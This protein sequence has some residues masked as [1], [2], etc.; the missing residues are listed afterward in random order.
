MG[1]ASFEKQ[2]KNSLDETLVN[3]IFTIENGQDLN[4]EDTVNLAYKEF[5]KYLSGKSSRTIYPSP[6][7]ISFNAGLVLSFSDRTGFEVG[8]L[9]PISGSFHIIPFSFSAE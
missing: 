8:H 5:N 1:S 2:L 9:M 3:N 7:H 4:I 6:D